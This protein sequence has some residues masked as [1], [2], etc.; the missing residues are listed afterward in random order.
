MSVKQRRDSGAWEVTV[1]LP[2]QPTVRKSNRNWSKRDAQRVELELLQGG[3]KAGTGQLLDDAIDK[4]RTEH[5]TFL[6]SKDRLLEHASALQ[7]HTGG[8][9]FEDLPDVI[10]RIK[11]ALANRKPATIN[12][13][14]AILRQI[15][16][17]AVSEWGWLD[18]PVAKV[19]LLREDNERHYYLTRAQVEAL[20]FA[21]PS[22]EVGQLIVFSAF[23][24]LRKSEMFRVR[25]E[26]VVNGS[27]LLDART[28]NGRPRTVPLH[29]RA[30]AIAEKMPFDGVTPK[31]LRDAWDDARAALKLKHIHWHDLRH[32][33]ASWLVQAGVSLLEVKELMGHSTIKMTERYAHL[34]PSNLTGAIR[35][36]GD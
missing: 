30:K 25:A 10:S 34:A 29:P 33:Y 8:L 16:N 3:P 28:K 6:R 26:H 15:Q 12:R 2:G 27:L 13:R 4:W 24:G 36:L 9:T 7:K 35:R 17:L 5:A 18:R 21:C 20:A 22:K 31:I 23:T 11:K 14:L 19:K 1:C 32:T